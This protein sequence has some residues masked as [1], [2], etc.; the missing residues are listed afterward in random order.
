MSIA[1]HILI[2]F[3]TK[4]LAPFEL[5]RADVPERDSEWFARCRVQQFANL[6]WYVGDIVRSSLTIW[7]LISGPDAA[8][9]VALLGIAAISIYAVRLKALL[10]RPVANPERRLN[11]I[12]RFL[13]LRGA[14]WAGVVPLLIC[15]GPSTRGI[16]MVFAFAPLLFDMVAMIA[17]PL[18]GVAVGTMMVGGMVTG[19]HHSGANSILITV[20]ALVAIIGFHFTLFNLYNLF[21][22]HRLH[23]RRLRT[24]NETIHALLSQYDEHGADAILEMDCNGRLIRMS[25]RLREMMGCT[26]AEVKTLTFGSLIE[27]GRERS[28]LMATARRAKRFRNHVVPLRLGRE[29]RWW[30]ISGCAVFDEDGT[31]TGYRCFA[32]DVTEQRATEERVHMMAT[33]DNLTGLPNRAVFNARLTK[34]VEAAWDNGSCGVLFIDLDFFKMVNDTYGHAAGDAVL[35]QAARR[36]EGLLGSDMMAAR[37]GGDEFAVLAWN[38]RDPGEL[39]RLGQAIVAELAKP[40]IRDGVLLPTGGS[41]GVAIGPDHGTRNETLLRAADI[42]LY[43]AKSLGRGRSVLFEERLL[44]KV[45][46]RRAFEVDLSGAL[47]RGEFALHYQPLIEIATRR[48][49]GYEALLRWNHPVRGEVSPATF[50]PLA[51]EAGLIEAIG[52]WVLRAALTEAATWHDDLTVSVNVSPVQMRGERFFDQVLEVLRETGV[53]PRRLEIEITE[54]ALMDPS[55]GALRTLH[56]LHGLGICIALDD[57]G[58]G[59]SSL[60]YLRSFPFNKLKVD[61][62]FVSDIAEQPDCHAIARTVVGLAREFHMKTTAEGVETEAQL[63]KLEAMGCTQAQGFLFD[64]ALPAA[65]IPAGHRKPRW[66]GMPRQHA[67]VA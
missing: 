34:V 54:T 42:A 65:R 16:V 63:R 28:A 66:H 26:M 18:I 24:A 51:E 6:P 23:S 5:I 55:D 29:R 46:E 37:L 57:F 31:Q 33:R 56:R 8:L 1:R 67:R 64:Q 38:L 58:T 9:V 14:V 53:S 61:R 44:H 48:T 27:P 62:S 41:A 59:Y 52:E 17:V 7:L 45:R 60:T 10:Q 21:T 47:E 30:S 36:I 12:R 39:L 20:A 2:K 32:Q 35:V 43:E 13:L 3:G 50:I 22:T 4:L 40:I 25:S 11:Q 19:L 49:I 15:T